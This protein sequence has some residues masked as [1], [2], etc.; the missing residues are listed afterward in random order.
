[1]TNPFEPPHADLGASR[2]GSDFGLAVYAVAS[3]SFVGTIVASFV[4]V[5][6]QASER[7]GVEFVLGGIIATSAALFAAWKGGVKELT[8]AGKAKI[9][10][11]L[12]ATAACAALV[13]DVLLGMS[14]YPEVTV[15]ISSLGAGLF[16]FIVG[17]RFWKA[18]QGT[19]RPAA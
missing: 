7:S 18:L 9:A 19:V 6:A 4:I 1:M 12:V 2:P 8:L 5:G 17:G 11:V 16:P 10:G 13:T 14:A 3:L 15:P